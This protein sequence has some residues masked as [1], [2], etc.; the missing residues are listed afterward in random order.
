MCATLRALPGWLPWCAALPVAAEGKCNKREADA[1][2][3]LR[4]RGE[5]LPAW[6]DK[7]L[8]TSDPGEGSGAA[9]S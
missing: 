4:A 9:T 2:P 3:P 7:D 1:H 5:E 6:A 8:G